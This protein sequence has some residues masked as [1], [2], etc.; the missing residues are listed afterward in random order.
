LI[1]NKRPCSVCG[2]EN[3]LHLDTTDTGSR[4]NSNLNVTI[5]T[6]VWS[7]GVFDKVVFLSV[8]CSITDS[9]NSVIKGCS[10]LSRGKDTTSVGLENGLVGLDGNGDWSLGN[11][12]LELVWVLLGN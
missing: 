1:H 2:W 6:P 3:W 8:L 5:D 7:P 4:C 10:A 12:S 11:G 9:K